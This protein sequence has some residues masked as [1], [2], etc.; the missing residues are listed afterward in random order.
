[1]KR[2][3][4]LTSVHK[5]NDIRI[6][7][8]ECCS[9]AKNG[10]KVVLIAPSTE[11]EK[12]IE[13]VRIR[14]IPIPKNRFERMTKSFLRICREARKE[15]ADIYHFHDP[16]LILLGIFLRMTGK[17]VLYD[18]HEDYPRQIMDKG[19][20]PRWLR[21]PLSLISRI[22]EF[23]AAHLLNGIVAATPV[24]AQKF[25]TDK[26]VLVQNFPILGELVIDNQTSFP[27]RKPYV[28]YVG[29]LTI[30]RGIKEMI[31]AVGILPEAKSVRLVLGG[32]FDSK[33]VEE[34]VRMLPGWD[35]VNYKG[36]LSRNDYR[37]LI[38]QCL[39]GLVL[40]HP[41]GNHIK[42][43]PN[44]LFE[45][46]SVGIPVIASNFPL[47]REFV[48]KNK[49]G[50]LVDPLNPNEIADGIRWILDHPEEAELM[51]KRGQEAVFSVYNW[52][53]EEKKL[54]QFYGEMLNC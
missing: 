28:I 34:Q 21:K 2:V 35:R 33:D 29:G 8:K 43:Q 53:V 5:Q 42:S 48:E 36:W 52:S 20:I 47:W 16:E 37:T 15:D 23:I 13:G 17:K 49:C 40:F 45:Y 31:E 27:K 3:V 39:A 7:I 22:V 19:W 1:M 46:M 24:I 32:N 50:L 10:Y 11:G 41:A 6:F 18:V 38:N 12:T 4:H 44:K 54:L 9:L 26:T 30:I 25:P 14:S 51:G